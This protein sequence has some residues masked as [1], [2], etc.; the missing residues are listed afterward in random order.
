MWHNCDWFYNRLRIEI[1]KPNQSIRL[2]YYFFCSEQSP[3]I[4]WKVSCKSVIDFNIAA[5][6]PFEITNLC[7]ALLLSCNLSEEAN[8]EFVLNSSGIS[9]FNNIDAFDI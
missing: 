4:S 3:T 8:M 7:K 2:C 6:D 1:T 9:D 5:S